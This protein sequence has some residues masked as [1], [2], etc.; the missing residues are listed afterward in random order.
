MASTDST[1]TPCTDNGDILLISLN[2]KAAL[3]PRGYEAVAMPTDWNGA[4]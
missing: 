2:G 1:D 3:P 4:P